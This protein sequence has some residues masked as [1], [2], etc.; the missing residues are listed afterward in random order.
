MKKRLRSLL[1]VS[2][3]L[4]GLAFAAPA[5]GAFQPDLTVQQSSYKAGAATT[6][7][8]VVEEL[9]TDDPIAK[10][11]IF[12]PSGYSSN[13]TQPQGA[14]IGKALAFVKAGALG[15]TILPLTGNVV[16]G[17]PADPTIMAQSHACTGSTT[18]QAVWI[19]DTSIQGQ[20]IRIPAFVNT[21][22]PYVVQQVCLQSPADPANT[23]A[24]QLLVA[25]YTVN[26]V[27]T[28]A[29]SRGGYQ[30]A[31]DFTPYVP[32]T[33]TVNP[34][35]TNEWRTY[36]GLPSSLSFKKAKSKRGQVAFS[37]ALAIAGLNPRGIKLHLYY[38]TKA[39]PAPNY[40]LGTAAGLFGTGKFVSTKAVKSNGKYSVSRKKP[41]G[42]KKW[43]YQARFENYLLVPSG[44]D[45]C[46]GPSPSGQP[47]PCNGTSLA[48]LTSASIRR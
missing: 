39:Q 7:G 6:A 13:L 38:S 41:K 1:V 14:V 40:S 12:S 24:A 29:A 26:G 32:G 48:P 11:T 28:N 36:V 31:A 10:F 5:L 43:F 25:N 2:A 44:G 21:V 17:N 15:G 4:L 34:A 3:G 8:F 30:W 18:N 19:L 35:G 9:D 45:N 37:G 47:I 42:K 16:V 22:G 46:S 27:F 23:F 20:S 33:T